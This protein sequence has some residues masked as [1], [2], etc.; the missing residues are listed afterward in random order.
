MT[1]T[2]YLTPYTSHPAHTSPSPL[3]HS[4]G[5]D[6]VSFYNLMNACNPTTIDVGAVGIPKLGMLSIL[7]LSGFT[8]IRPWLFL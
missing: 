1:T 3:Y 5:Q 7:N 2:K 4:P 6:I 8:A